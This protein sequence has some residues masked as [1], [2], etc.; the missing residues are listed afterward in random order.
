[1]GKAFP[2]EDFFGNVGAGYLAAI[3]DFLVFI[4]GF[5][6]LVLGVNGQENGRD[7]D[8]E[9]GVVVIHNLELGI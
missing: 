8:E 1:M 7:D 6:D 3:G 4:E 9:G 2:R 5:F